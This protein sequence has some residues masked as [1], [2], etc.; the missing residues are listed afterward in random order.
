M[1]K[2]HMRGNWQERKKK[3]EEEKE[4]KT[5]TYLTSQNL[6]LKASNSPNHTKH[7][8][9]EIDNYRTTLGP[10]TPSPQFT[11]GFIKHNSIQTHK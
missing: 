9:P 1:N 2:Q 6:G 10:F 5:S 3:K 7:Q 11:Y 4:K 8:Q